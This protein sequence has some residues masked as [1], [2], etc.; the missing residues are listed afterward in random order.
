MIAPLAGVLLVTAYTPERIF[1]YKYFQ[2]VV[3]WLFVAVAHVGL[4][5]GRV[6][7]RGAGLVAVL[8]IA[9]NLWACLTWHSAPAFWG[10]QPWR[11]VLETVEPRMEG[12]D[13]LLVHP[14]MMMAPV[15]AYGYF[16]ARLRPCVFDPGDKGGGTVLRVTGV[17]TPSDPQLREALARSGRVWLLLTPHHPW[18]VRQRLE[19]ALVPLWQ[20]R[21][22]WDT[23][24]FWPANRIRVLLLVPRKE[25][26]GVSTQGRPQGEGE[27]IGG[28]PETS[29]GA[30]AL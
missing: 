16:E 20:A 3:P 24:G 9:A 26:V 18:V 2:S 11:Q 21:T 29:G 19:S 6:L 5:P 25:R 15:L 28:G 1:E 23:D 7:R 4:E 8:L 27:R 22:V 14:S 30:K 10:P 13:Q 12:G 17:D